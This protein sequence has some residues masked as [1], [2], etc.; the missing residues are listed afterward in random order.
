MLKQTVFIQTIIIG[1][2]YAAVVVKYMF[3]RITFGTRH[4]NNNTVKGWTIWTLCC[5]STWIFGWVIG[6][7]VPFFGVSGWPECRQGVL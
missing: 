3:H 2:I 5:A 1:V 7:A 6:E 4:Y